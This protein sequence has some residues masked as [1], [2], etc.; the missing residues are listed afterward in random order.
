MTLLGSGPTAVVSVT[1]STRLLYEVRAPSGL[2]IYRV[3]L[4]NMSPMAKHRGVLSK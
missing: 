1:H 2:L 4:E 3:I